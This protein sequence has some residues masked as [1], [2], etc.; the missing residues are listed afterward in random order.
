MTQHVW[1][2][3]MMD[4]ELMMI[5]LGCAQFESL[6]DPYLGWFMIIKR[7][8]SLPYLPYQLMIHH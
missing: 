3:S 7:H 5:H 8:T 6:E 1:W 4:Y 2:C